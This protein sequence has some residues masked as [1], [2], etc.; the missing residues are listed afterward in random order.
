MLV[1]ANYVERLVIDLETGQRGFVIT[2]DA[3]FLQPWSHARATLPRQTAAL[4]RLAGDAGQ[5]EQARQITRAVD[6]YIHDYSV[7]T[8]E[9]GRRDP[10]SVRTVA[11][12]EEG[13]RRIDSIRSQFDRFVAFERH[14]L[15]ERQERAAAAGR[16]AA[17]AAAAGVAASVLL[18]LTFDGYMIRSIVRPV[19]RASV[20]ARHLAD[21]DLSMRMPATAPGE[22]GV[23]E[24]SFNTMATS[25]EVSRGELHRIAEEQA[26]LRRVATV[27]AQA[28]SPSVV[29]GAVA[30]EMGHIL[31]ADCTAIK[32][33]EADE[34]VTVVG[35]WSRPGAPQSPPPLGSR[36]P[37]Q[38]ESV[39][40]LVSRTGRPARVTGN[41]RSAAIPAWARD[42]GITSSV[43][44]PIM[45][46]ERL[47]GVA[48]GF[49][50]APE[51]LPDDT[52]ERML[53]FTELVATAIANAESRA[54]LAASRARVV[55]AADESRRRIERDLHD[56]T[57]QRLVSLAL[58]VR[59]AEAAVPPE[60]DQ[61]KQQVSRVAS[62]LSAAVEELQELSRGL[63]PA[64]LS[65]G[66]IAF[67]LKA[68]AR[69]SAIPVELNVNVSRRLAERIEV[70]AYYVVSEALTNAAKH[71][72]ASVVHV[73]LTVEGA[74]LKLSVRDDGI[75]G[76][77]PQHGSG[78]IGLMDRVQ[79]IGGRIHI[80]SPAGKGTALFV[81][82]PIDDT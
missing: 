57:Q 28:A 5:R 25:L 60:Q 56:G 79:A 15:T 44:S 71:G 67:A 24:R 48:T 64:I 37:I 4:Q 49:S 63:H 66:G 30:A 58:D 52:E 41:K 16:Q 2:G 42:Q 7:P 21:G 6:T 80:D 73:D 59:M 50:A 35:A 55:A 78:L 74:L 51:P 1:T 77:D 53:E 46:E 70:A 36:W 39:S 69:R 26:A 33:Y 27:V 43:G 76:A 47:W 22:I 17:L 62:G 20:M 75:G 9:A 18:V 23:L 14:L 38:D 10:A 31:E 13:K 68:L 65:S 82:I 19:R 45:V 40:A 3:R 8:V 81:S 12:T 54:E 72:H 29:F 34:T 11:V 61:L 32:R